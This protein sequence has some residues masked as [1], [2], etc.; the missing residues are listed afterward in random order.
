ME[1]A[2]TKK[3]KKKETKRM[4][5]TCNCFANTLNA[6]AISALICK[7]EEGWYSQPK[8]SSVMKNNT[9]CSDLLC[10]SLWTS[11]FWFNT[12]AC[13]HLFSKWFLDNQRSVKMFAF[14]SSCD[15]SVSNWFVFV[16]NFLS[17]DPILRLAYLT[18]AR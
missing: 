2:K 15:S 5:E 6:R 9:R 11:R 1:T 13:H 8:Y 4:C 17:S 10:S 18:R 3:K 14:L 16:F 7:P 12:N